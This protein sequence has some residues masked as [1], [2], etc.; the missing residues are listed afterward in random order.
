M[1]FPKTSEAAA[2][3]ILD[4]TRVY[5]EYAR[6]KKES[7]E[8][9]GSLYWK[10]VGSYEYLVRKVRG[11]V[12]P[13]GARSSETER[14]FEEFKQ[15]QE[16]LKQRLKRLKTSVESC[17]RLNK[18]VRAGA[19]PTPVV[20]VLHRL[21]ETGLSE[22][23]VVLGTPALF[24]YSQPA[25]VRLEELA[26]PDHAESVVDEA[27]YHLHILVH[28]SENAVK[29]ALPSLKAEAEVMVAPAGGGGERTYHFFEFKFHSKRATHKCT[30]KD[31]HWRSVATEMAQSIER[32]GKFE[33]VVIGKTGTMATMRTLDPKF[34]ALV[35]CAAAEACP[36]SLPDPELVRWQAA[37]VDSLI[38][39]DLL[40]PKLPEAE[41][42]RAVSRIKELVFRM[43]Q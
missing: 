30:A 12:T 34:F 42:R 22:G 36:A 11:K 21:E 17:Q 40:V 38:T 28:A 7:E 23:S 18:A 41:C 43:D 15:K 5:R 35:N 25:G 8:Y 31:A 27:Q 4:S 10:K 33:Q 16:T 2:K 6:V 20:E 9:L 13:V 29:A 32:A 14:E 3:Q 19:V 1:S 24:A 39:D 26:W 37:L